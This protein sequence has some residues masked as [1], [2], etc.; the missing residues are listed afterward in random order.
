[1]SLELGAL[2]PSKAAQPLNREKEGR[3][4]QGSV[5]WTQWYWDRRLNLPLQ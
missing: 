3:I 5:R 1:M 4:R 2:T